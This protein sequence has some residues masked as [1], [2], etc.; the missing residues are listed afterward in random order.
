MAIIPNTDANMDGSGIA[1]NEYSQV[2]SE[3]IKV[4]LSS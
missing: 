3:S 1:T 2:L 4:S